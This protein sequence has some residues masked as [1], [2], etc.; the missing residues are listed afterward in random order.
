MTFEPG[1]RVVYYSCLVR[2][3]GHG[4][5]VWRHRSC[6]RSGV[7]VRAQRV[8][9]GAYSPDRPYVPT[10]VGEAL[11]VREDSDRPGPVW[12]D[13]VDPASARQAT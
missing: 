7:V 8:D 6:L 9:N 10:A 12:W 3:V 2:H 11:L 4:M 13:L 5:A 1:D